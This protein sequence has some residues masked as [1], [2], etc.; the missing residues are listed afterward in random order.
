MSTTTDTNQQIIVVVVAGGGPVGLTFA[1]NLTMMMGKN[2]KIIIY[3]GRW[4]V[5]GQG[6]MRWQ[7]EKQGKTRRDQ[8]VTLQD[9]VIEQMPDYIKQGLFRNIE[10]RVW[11]TSRNIP[12]REVEDRLFDLLKPFVHNGQIE[13][14]PE[15]LNEQSE[16]LIKGN[17]D[18]LVGADGANSFVRRYCN[19]QMISEGLEYACGVAYNIPNDVPSSEAPL[20]QA[21]N[22]VLTVSQTRYL[23]N[24]ST[25]RHGYLNI[26]LTHD[27]MDELRNRLQT[28]QSNNEPINLLDYNKC[29]QSPVWTIIRQGLDFFRISPKY[30]FRV[31]PIEINVRHASIVVRELRFEIDKSERKPRQNDEKKYKTA[32]AFLA[33]DA[34]MCVHFWPGRGMNSG[35]KAAMALARNIVRTCTSKNSINIRKP[36]RFLDF[37]D[38]EG[39]MARLRAREQQGRSLRVLVN[40][41]DKSV[42]ESYSYGHSYQCY[43]KYTKKLIRKLKETR[44]RLEERPEWPHHASPISDD[45]LSNTLQCISHLAVA[46][47]SLANPWPTRAMSGV[48]VLCEDIYPYDLKN[49][50]PVPAA[51]SANVRCAPSAPILDKYHVLWIIGEKKNESFNN[52]ISDVRNL[53]NAPKS[54]TDTDSDHILTVLKTV[55][56][57]EEWVQRNRLL[58]SQPDVRFKVVTVWEIGADKTAIDIIRA[59]RSTL[60]RAPVLIFTNKFQ[61]VQAALQY[62]NVISTDAE[63]EVKEFVGFRQETLWNAGYPVRNENH[64]K[65]IVSS[66]LPYPPSNSNRSL[67]PALPTSISFFQLSSS[68]SRPMPSNSTLKP[69]ILWIDSPYNDLELTKRI[70]ERHQTVKINFQTTYKEAEE[71]LTVNLRQIRRLPAF[72]TICRGFYRKDEKNYTDIAHLFDILN[73]EELPLAVYTSSVINLLGKINNPPERVKIFDQP[74]ALFGFINDCLQNKC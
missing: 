50:F 58:I 20:H 48:E 47:L 5:D 32:L 21:M 53:Q 64:E 66:A 12:I 67:L 17:F 27:E 10:E 44:D 38:Y 33:G 40:P 4:F 11:P 2:A 69:M 42:E 46:Q 35:M 71:Y 19:I 18:I 29:P 6:E 22:C 34:A 57:T 41:I 15:N 45:K 51:P 25:S 36:L 72:I 1:L 70:Q 26:R 28:F 56:E 43:E 63:L 49:V 73:L 7:D 39:F 9:H 3:E 24:S 74:S 13:L 14:V 30:V 54:C 31:I 16:C 59:V 37:L 62:P 68:S 55:E 60:S 65:T 61:E 52:L 8:V 23:V